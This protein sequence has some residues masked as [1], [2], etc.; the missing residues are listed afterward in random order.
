MPRVID[1]PTLTRLL[2]S[3][4]ANNLV[5]LCGAGVS[6]ASPSNLLPARQV[7]QICYDKY[8]PVEKLPSAFRDDIC[9]LAGHFY[10]SGQLQSVFLKGLVPWNDLV[11][12]PNSGHQAIG[13]LLATR[14]AS[15]ALT[16]N[17]D[18]MIEQWAKSHK[19]AMRGA[20]EPAEAA[21]FANVTAPLLKLHGCIDRNR[22][23]TLWALQQL[24]EPG[25]QNRVSSWAQWIHLNLPGKD[26]LIIGFWTDWNYLNGAINTVLTGHG[27]ASVTVIDPLS[28]AD[29]Q[30]N[31]P[32]LWSTL[33]LGTFNHVQASGNVA[34]EELRVAFSR[35]WLRKF[36]QFGKPLIDASDGGCSP[37]A[38]EPPD[39][40]VSDLYNMRR[41]AEGIP[42]H[43]A[44]QSQEPTPMCTQAAFAHL[45]LWRANPARRAAWY[46]L[47]G[48]SV[49]V[50]NGGGQML[51]TVRERY[52][53]PPAVVQADVVVCAGATDLGVPGHLISRGYGAS[54]VRPAPGGTSKWITLEA[55]MD[56]W[57]L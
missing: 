32:A 47:G 12:E 8:R 29:L 15:A 50:V 39:G 1:E 45:L 56:E 22:D 57:H 33:Q 51:S 23:E 27:L 4:E 26:L 5:L 48:Q 20:V 25:V 21:P 3:I 6:I 24:E 19:L 38:F 30:V 11:G 53:E 37:A 14:A 34:L 7:A 9:R 42:Y 2:G 55:A 13:D 49:R 41:D 52:L 54:T 18:T 36:F 31:A 46:D 10:D 17:F 43:R 40:P 16:T 44:A 28:A 35:V